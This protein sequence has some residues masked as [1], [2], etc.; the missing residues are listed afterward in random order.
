MKENLNPKKRERELYSRLKRQP[1]FKK[2]YATDV[3]VNL[4]LLKNMTFI[5]ELGPKNRLSAAK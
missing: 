3:I 1:I 2:T 4:L 5:A